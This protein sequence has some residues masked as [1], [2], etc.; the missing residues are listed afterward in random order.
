W[1]RLEI[2]DETCAIAP[3]RKEHALPIDRQFSRTRSSAV[4]LVG[5]L[6]LRSHTA[7][8]PP[9]PPT[10]ASRGWAHVIKSFRSFAVKS[11]FRTYLRYDGKV[12]PTNNDIPGRVTYRALISSQLITG[13]KVGVAGE[14]ASMCS[15][16]STSSGESQQKFCTGVSDVL[17][18]GIHKRINH[19]WLNR[20]AVRNAYNGVAKYCETKAR[21]TFVSL[22]EM[23]F[24]S[25][26]YNVAERRAIFSELAMFDYPAH[27]Y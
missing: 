17:R 10:P 7:I 22:M 26:H 9:L 5:K 6:G 2:V 24:L 15:A 18:N 3:Q 25:K 16:S 4:C 23:T 13:R 21:L 27:N 20:T 8:P 12:P 14:F 1:H 19:V 11:F